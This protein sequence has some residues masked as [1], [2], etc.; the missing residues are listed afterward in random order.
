MTC[1]EPTAT[2]LTADAFEAWKA[3]APKDQLAAKMFHAAVCLSLEQIGV[4]PTIDGII[5]VLACLAEECPGEFA[6]LRLMHSDFT[7]GTENGT[8]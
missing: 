1:L 4:V 5:A 6:A 7:A 8:H 3:G 2:T